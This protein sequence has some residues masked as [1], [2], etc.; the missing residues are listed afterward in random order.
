MPFD[1]STA[2]V[3]ESYSTLGNDALWW[4]ATCKLWALGGEGRTSLMAGTDHIMAGTC[5]GNM[6]LIPRVNIFCR[7]R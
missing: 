7:A 5:L 3:S 2:M 6:I 4:V 1:Q